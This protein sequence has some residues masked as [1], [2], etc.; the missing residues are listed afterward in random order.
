M[1][2]TPVEYIQYMFQT[3]QIISY[4]S[5]SAD[6]KLYIF[7]DREG[8]IYH[9]IINSDFENDLKLNYLDLLLKTDQSSCT[10]NINLSSNNNNVSLN[11]DQTSTVHLLYSTDKLLNSIALDPYSNNIFES[12][13]NSR[14]NSYHSVP[15]LSRN[16]MDLQGVMIENKIK[17]GKI[18]RNILKMNKK[19][20][21]VYARSLLVNSVPNNVRENIKCRG[22]N[23]ILPA[24]GDIVD[25]IFSNYFSCYAIIIYTKITDEPMYYGVSLVCLKDEPTKRDDF[26]ITPTAAILVLYPSRKF[27][28]QSIK[29]IQQIRD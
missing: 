29:I 9:S 28:F 18:G 5:A 25:V 21:I 27:Q 8:K 22:E 23:L 19:E 11:T 4:Q 16:N 7:I 20:K 26:G 2:T 17:D 14:M 12:S 15:Q 3:K 13:S 1:T 10:N 24:V 6:N